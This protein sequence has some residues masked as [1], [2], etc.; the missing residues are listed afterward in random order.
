MELVS[1]LDVRSPSKGHKIN[2]RGHVMIIRGRKKGKNVLLH[3]QN[4]CFH[5]KVLDNLL[6]PLK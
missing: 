1:L 4:S 3:T 5:V 6:G 2:L